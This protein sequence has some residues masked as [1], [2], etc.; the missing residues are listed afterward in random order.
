MVLARNDGDK[1]V[2]INAGTKLEQ[3]KPL[4]EDRIGLGQ[5]PQE[6]R[7]L[8]M[9]PMGQLETVRHA[10]RGALAQ[11]S[12][13]AG[14][15]LRHEERLPSGITIFRDKG[16]R[17]ELEKVLTKY[18]ARFDTE[19]GNVAKVPEQDRIEIPLVDN[20]EELYKPGQAKVYQMGR[21]DRDIIDQTFNKLQDQ[22]RLEWT[23]NATPFSFPCFMVWTKDDKG[24]PKGRV[25]VDIRALN[26]ITVP[27]TYPVP[28]QSD[29]LAEVAGSYF[30]TVMDA[31]SFFYQ[32]LVKAGHRYRLTVLSHRGQETFQCAVMGFRNS[33]AYVQRMIDTILRR[34]KAFARAYVDDIV[35]FSRTFKEHLRHL[36]EVF[37]RLEEFDIVLS[38]KKS[39]IGF[40]SI[41]LLGQKVD[42]FGLAT[43]KEKLKAIASLEFPR[44]LRQLEHHL[45]LISYLRQYIPGYAAVT[46]LLQRRKTK[47]NEVLRMNRRKL[48]ELGQ[49]R[50]NPKHVRDAARLAVLDPTDEEI[51]S[52]KRLQKLFTRPGTLRHYDP[53]LRLY[54]DIDTSKERG[55]SAFT[56][57]SV[58]D[59]PSPKTKQPILF[60]SKILSPAETRYWPTELEVAGLVWTVKK[61]RHMIEAL[62]LTTVI[63]TDHAVTINLVLKTSVETSSVVRLNTRHI[64]AAEFLSR[65]D[66]L[67]RHIA[68][69]DNTVPDALFRLPTSRDKQNVKDDVLDVVEAYPVALIQIDSE[70]QSKIK[71]GYTTDK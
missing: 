24:L 62:H 19:R 32:W 61:L 7:D 35:I 37:E 34:Q 23:K 41:Q 31:A 6:Y 16:Q 50:S 71:M 51:Q 5:A 64:R 29:I 67:V 28:K 18:R 21:R 38:P 4:D 49:A 42:A 13:K 46:E 15:G 25:V 53:C 52:F 8:A 63:Y 30:L 47:L 33:P 69:K 60:L 68:E 36:D 48:K 3:L 2:E 66:I 70:F 59:P 27:D 65:F 39:F 1:P 11:S 12:M 54:I 17:H 14:T 44:T 55:F 58:N 26:K 22:G 43:D 57:H 20:W 9:K 40:P 10:M 56:Y 45:S